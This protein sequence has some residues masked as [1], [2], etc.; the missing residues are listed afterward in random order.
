MNNEAQF[1][2]IVKNSLIESGGIGFK[3]S[4][5]AGSLSGGFTI[6]SPFD[7]FG[8]LHT[9][10]KNYNVY[11]ESKFNKEMKSINLNRIED[12]QAANLTAYNVTDSSLCL[13]I[14]GVSVSRGDNRAYIFYWNAIKKYF[15]NYSIHAK[16]LEKLPYN[17]IHKD[18]F[19]F[20]NIINEEDLNMITLSKIE[21]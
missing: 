21:K 17:E 6:Q 8:I 7:G 5:M 1:N 18:V 16:E 11:W 15:P 20:T 9:D 14:L 4:D 19:K 3:I 10:K 12:H 13:F 2:T